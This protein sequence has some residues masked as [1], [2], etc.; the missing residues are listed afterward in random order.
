VNDDDDGRT[1]SNLSFTGET[2]RDYLIAV[3]G[4]IFP[5]FN[6]DAP[7][8]GAIVLNWILASQPLL[9]I[10]PVSNNRV[11]ITW[12]SQATNFV[13]QVAESLE[14]PV[15]WQT[16]NDSVMVIGE[17][18]AITVV[19]TNRARFYRLIKPYCTF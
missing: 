6:S 5:D 15:Q 10:R 14:P 3:D 18:L 13:L 12:A 2:G 8:M 19:G 11:E 16:A 4:K 1:T 7:P 9:S 17:Q